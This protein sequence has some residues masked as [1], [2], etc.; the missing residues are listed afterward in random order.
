MNEFSFIEYLKR[1]VPRVKHV[2]VGIGDDAA[3][4]DVS[5]GKRLVVSTDAIVEGV[6][7]TIHQGAKHPRAPGT[8]MSP[9]QIGRK[10]LA[11]NLSDMA[12]MGAK[13]V[14]FVITVGKPAYISTA[15]LKHFYGGLLKLARRYDVACAGGDFSSAKEMFAS[16]TILGEVLP[17]HCV[18]RSGAMAGDWIAVTG[19]LGGS[20]LRHHHDFSPRVCE[21]LFLA[22][23]ITPT[24]MID[25]SDGFVQDLSHILK[26]S[27]VG[28]VLE[29]E[30]IPVS[31]DAKRMAKGDRDKAL[32]M[33]LSDGEDFELLFTVPPWRKVM[34]EKLW[35][36]EFPK[37]RLSWVGKI[38][39]KTP[40]VTWQRNGKNIPKP[41]L[42]HK[43][44]SHF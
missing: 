37:V 38:R 4:I 26:A 16:V 9:G 33:A 11:I 32:A 39:G 25:V 20:I 8:L 34:L 29:L 28:A 2:P 12:A 24:A 5:A 41:K 7:F 1:Q 40:V 17:R 15:W 23:H 22:H 3:V 30:G 42:Y 13:P 21:G 35:K 14:A 31:S 19:A 6:D 44:F 18:T 27:G 10:A 43:G 36:K